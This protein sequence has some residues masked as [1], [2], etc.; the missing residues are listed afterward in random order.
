MA[1]VHYPYERPAQGVGSHPF[2]QKGMPEVRRDKFEEGVEL[3]KIEFQRAALNRPSPLLA[4]DF[5][6]SARVSPDLSAAIDH[7]VEMDSD[8]VDDRA[9]RMKRLLVIASLLQPLRS[10]LDDLKYECARQIAKDLNVAFTA[11]VVDAFEWPDVELPLRYVIGF[12]VVFDIPDSGVYKPTESPAE[13]PRDEFM[14]GNTR[15]NASAARNL[16]QRAQKGGDDLERLHQCWKRTVEEEQEGLILGPLSA[17]QIDRKYGRGRWRFL[18]RTAILQ[19]GKWRCIDDAKRSKTNSA[20]T[21]HETIVCARADWPALISREF[22]RR[23]HSLGRRGGKRQRT[24]SSLGMCH[25]TDDL[26]AAYRHVPTAQPEFTLVG[27]WRPDDSLPTGGEVVYF[28]VPGHNFGLVSAVCNFNRSPELFTAAARRL[29]GIVTEH[30]FDDAD[31]CEPGFAGDS[32][33]VALGTLHGPRLFGFPFDQGKHEHMAPTHEFL[34]VETDFSSIHTGVVLLDVTQK[35]RGKLSE[36]C[37]DTLALP[38]VTHALAQSIVGKGSF[39]LSATFSSVGRSCLQPLQQHAN[40]GAPTPLSEWARD[41]LEFL[42]LV[43]DIMPPTRLPLLPVSTKP[44]VVFVDAEGKRRKRGGPGPPTGHVGF[45]VI[46]PTLGSF[47]G[48]GEV[49]PSVV[50]LLDDIKVRQTYIGQFELIGAIVPF[51]SLPADL[52]RGFPV[53][54][55]IDNSGAIGSLVKGYS[56]KPDCAKLVNMFNFAISR[57]GV[58]SLFI[59]YVPTD[60][61]VAD[62]P[63]RWHEM[64]PAERAE[65]A[66]LLGLEVAAKIPDLANADG[67]WRSYTEMA[68]ALWA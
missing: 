36:L 1:I 45:K 43:C 17:A 66:G 57:A 19:K 10:T 48:H 29:L 53:E 42:Q 51:V 58:A 2:I 15:A 4:L 24:G 54:L 21:M 8:I 6:A 35:R 56:G 5:A 38:V 64:S 46:H 3:D 44:I 41:S 25:G 65:W 52:F 28:E 62:V 23:Y 55:W 11:A 7:I 20:T 67:G 34:G 39:A 33:Q 16:A 40:Q 47:W 14:A 49:P 27:V 9:E 63:S 60:S 12:P 50:K 18:P 31:T 59:D 13:I 32:G 37:K 30:Y 22:A 68:R 61:N 26:R